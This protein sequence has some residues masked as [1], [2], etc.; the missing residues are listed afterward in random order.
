[1]SE[2]S[3][4]YRPSRQAVGTPNQGRIN[5]RKEINLKRRRRQR[6]GLRGGA[7]VVKIHT[8]RM[9][10]HLYVL[11][12]CIRKHFL[13]LHNSLGCEKKPHSSG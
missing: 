5:F 7:L 4:Q 3:Q 11:Y 12:I 9:H 6:R 2:A 1:M 10:T 8:H 13:W